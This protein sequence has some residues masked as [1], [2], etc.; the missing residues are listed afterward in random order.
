MQVLAEILVWLNRFANVLGLVLLAPM[1]W[2]PGWLS[3]TIYAVL[4]GVIMLI[5]FK[6]TSN[7]KAIGRIKDQMKA[8]LLALKLYKDFLPVTLQS[9]GILLV[10]AIKQL[11]YAVVPLAVMSLPVCLLLAQMG[12]WYQV[13]PLQ[14]GE[15]TLVVATLNSEKN[16][17]WP[18]IGLDL[19]AGAQ[20][21]VA[22]CLVNK[23]RQEVWWSVQAGEA[24]HDG[25][26]ITIAG[27]RFEKE[28]VVTT[29][30]ERVSALR[31]ARRWLD[32]LLH[33]WE[34]PF[35]TD[36]RV[37]SIEVTYPPRRSF[38][39]GTNHW[40]IYFF[41]VSIVGAFLFKPFFNVKI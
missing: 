30:L 13:R 19:P 27:E 31:P 11:V 20:T 6:Y 38:T 40:V 12:L 21:L 9:Q 29:E 35:A 16:T 32:L 25:L 33:P 4:A 39:H 18:Q 17:P 41:I 1:R 24:G 15:Q 22:P 10:C 36:S 26:A 7:Q 23:D 28:F 14:S 34:T 5:V 8:G 3:S 2:L 37:Q